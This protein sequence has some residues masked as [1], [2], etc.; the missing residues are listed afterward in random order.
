MDPSPGSLAELDDGKMVEDEAT[1]NTA[2]NP[3]FPADVPV[4]A[5]S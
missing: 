5:I 4:P 2:K 3:C 1:R